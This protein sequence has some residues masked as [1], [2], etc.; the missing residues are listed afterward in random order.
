M[1]QGYYTLE[2]S[3]HILGMSPDELKQLARKGEIRSFQ[4]RGTWRFR[5]QDIQEMARR[6]TGGSD[7]ELAVGESLTP[8]PTDSPAPR[9]PKPKK[10]SDD[11]FTFALD[12]DDQAD[13]GSSPKLDKPPSGSGKK[14]GSSKRLTQNAGDSGVRL[15][16]EGDVS[17]NVP[18]DSSVKLGD[19]GGPKSATRS[20]KTG[21][22]GPKSPKSSKSRLAEAPA[23]SGVR[24]VPDSDSD[25]R[26]LGSDDAQVPIGEQPVKGPTDSEVRL[27]GAIPLASTS[28]VEG[29]LTDEIDLDEELAKEAAKKQKPTKQPELPKKSPFDLSQSELNLG[30]AKSSQLKTKDPI[31]DSSSD[32]DLTPAA[33]SSSPLELGSDEFKLADD[34]A[35]TLGEEDRSSQKGPLSGINIGHPADSGISLEQTDQIEDDGDFELTLEPEASTP[36]PAK[37]STPKPGAGK[38]AEAE[39]D[40]DSSEFELSLDADAAAAPEGDSEFELTLDDTGGLAVED[41]AA[42]DKDIFET[43]FEVPALDD[44]SGS[45]AV[46]VDGETDLASSD[47]ELAIGEE[48]EAGVDES[49]SEVVALDEEFEVDE[50][51]EAVQPRK[52]GK[53]TAFAVDDAGE[54]GELEEGGDDIVVEEEEE[55]VVQTVTIQQA[56]WGIF[57]VAV[58]LPCVI[59]MV[60][61][62]MMGFEL[63]Q[64]QQGYKPGMLTKAIGGLIDGKK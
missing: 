7:L 63:V 6:R 62:G 29:A 55:P 19:S 52:R 25:V 43:D 50:E 13:L 32:F 31:K 54:F 20:S 27:E 39:D 47:F 21:M 41:D 53:K 37:P 49:G 38:L 42:Q 8:M 60:L 22:G 23:D 10:T 11:V 40:S 45:E 17:F 58:L 48:E 33:E 28:E 24:L 12:T 26:I 16:D 44:E 1:V 30:P 61:L 59:V 5:I 34:D 14:T 57:P 64:A 56:P 35:V 36:K 9:S 51:G 18:A 46:A 3:A 4:D 15:V 2:E